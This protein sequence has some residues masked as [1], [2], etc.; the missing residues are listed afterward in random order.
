MVKTD[1]E[2]AK[3]KADTAKMNVTKTRPAPAK[4][5]ASKGGPR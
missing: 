5:P 1:T 3:V 2:K 4:V